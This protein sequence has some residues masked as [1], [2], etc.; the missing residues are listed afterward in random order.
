MYNEFACAFRSVLE[1]MLKK[2][3]YKYHL[4]SRLKDEKSLEEKIERKELKGKIYKKL[5]DIQDVVGIRVIFYTENDRKRFITKLQKELS[6]LSPLSTKTAS[7]SRSTATL[8]VWNARS[9]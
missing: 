1:N 2:E 3:G 9:S 5:K 4:Y 8:K 6:M 7:S